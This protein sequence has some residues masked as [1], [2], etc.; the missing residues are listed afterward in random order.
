LI[1][2]TAETQEVLEFC[3]KHN[4]LPQ[5]E[6]IDIKDINDAFDKIKDDEVYFRYVID[7]ATLKS[8]PELAE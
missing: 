1:G 4:I 8:N 3:A 2:G 7:M 5:V 6:L